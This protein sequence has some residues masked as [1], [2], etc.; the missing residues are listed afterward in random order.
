MAWLNNAGGCHRHSVGNKVEEQ[1]REQTMQNLWEQ[2]PGV[3]HLCF[4]QTQ[5]YEYVLV[6]TSLRRAIYSPLLP[7]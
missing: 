4:I 2:R 3:I 1:E 7:L 5:K 6:I